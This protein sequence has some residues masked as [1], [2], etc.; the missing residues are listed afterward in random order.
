MCKQNVSKGKAFKIIYTYFFVNLGSLGC[1]VFPYWNVDIGHVVLCRG[2]REVSNKRAKQGQFWTCK[3]RLKFDRDIESEVYIYVGQKYRST[4]H[5]VH[6]N[7][8]EYEMESQISHHVF[9]GYNT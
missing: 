9:F 5:P 1:R 7:T 8:P 2:E 6:I 4:K 3:I